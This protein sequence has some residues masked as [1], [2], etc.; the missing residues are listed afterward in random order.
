[1]TTGIFKKSVLF[2]TVSQSLEQ[3]V[4]Y[5]KCLVIMSC[6]MNEQVNDR[7]GGL[8]GATRVRPQVGAQGPDLQRV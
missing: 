4:T 3:R 2:T 6:I 7:L 8:S 1:M 5:G